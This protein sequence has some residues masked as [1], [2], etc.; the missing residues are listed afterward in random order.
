MQKTFSLPWIPSFNIDYFMGMDGISF[1]LVILTTFI[2]MVSMAASWPIEKNVKAYCILF[3]LLETGMLG[4]FL[5]LDFFLF[6]VFWEVML[7]PMYFLIGV[8]GGPRREYAAI[9]FFLY[10][11]LGSVLMLI[12]IL[13]LYFTS[14]LRELDRG[15]VGGRA[16][17]L[18]R[19]RTRPTA[20]ASKHRNARR[21]AAHVQ[22]PGPAANGPAHR[23]CSTADAVLGKSAAVVG[24]FAAVH[25]LHHQGAGGAACTP[26]CPMRT[27]RPPRRSR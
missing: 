20:E 5:A 15:A 27:S 14:D 18:A 16:R 17:R 2:S 9:K 26:G 13:M 23:I 3:L 25:R 8:W 19:A 10:T 22:Y 4:V 1:P 21:A 11:L 12:A 6:Y 7:L 24:V